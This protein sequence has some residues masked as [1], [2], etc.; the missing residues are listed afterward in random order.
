M[1]GRIRALDW[2]DWP[3]SLCTTV[4]I[5]L[6]SRYAMWLA[7]GAELSFYCNDAYQPTLMLKA[8]PV[9]NSSGLRE[10]RR[11]LKSSKHRVTLR[12]KKGSPH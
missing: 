3:Q 8:Q 7:W 12:L 6:G 9:P 1:S 10:Q 11:F 2:A 4:E 5:M